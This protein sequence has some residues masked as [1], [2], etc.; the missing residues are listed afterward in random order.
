MPAHIPQHPLHVV[1]RHFVACPRCYLLLENHS[2]DQRVTE[3]RLLK[4]YV[5]QRALHLKPM[6]QSTAVTQ[7][8][9]WSL[10]DAAAGAM[11]CI[12]F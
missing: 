9:T 3:E 12:F 2:T 11:A 1:V 10:V 8:S 4:L 7:G 6:R 5:E